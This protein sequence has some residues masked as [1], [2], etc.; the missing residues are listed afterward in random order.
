VK[1]RITTREI[2]MASSGVFQAEIT[3]PLGGPEDDGGTVVLDFE[4]VDYI[5][6]SGL[7]AIAVVNARLRAEGRGLTVERP[8]TIVERVFTLTGLEAFLADPPSG[9]P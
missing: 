9:R 1:V 4:D 5:D 7:A 6:S 2:D 8:S 3:R